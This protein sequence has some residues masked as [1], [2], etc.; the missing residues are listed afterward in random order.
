MVSKSVIRLLV[1]IF[2]INISGS[3]YSI[4]LL[5][6]EAQWAKDKAV[7]LKKENKLNQL[8]R[9]YKNIRELRDKEANGTAT[10]HELNEL[11]R[12]M[13]QI[14]KGAA[15]IGITIAA[16]A[17]LS[18]IGLYKKTTGKIS[19][20][21]MLDAS[22]Y[23]ITAIKKKI[24]DVAHAKGISPLTRFTYPHISLVIY[25]IP[26]TN[27]EEA[28]YLLHENETDAIKGWLWAEKIVP[29]PFNPITLTPKEVTVIGEN[30]RSLVI[31]FN[32]DDNRMTQI[33][34]DLKMHLRKKYSRVIFPHSSVRPHI[35]IGPINDDF[36]KEI[37]KQLIDSINK[38]GEFK[39]LEIKKLV[40]LIMTTPMEIASMGS[41]DQRLHNNNVVLNLSIKL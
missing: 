12:R 28:T 20:A 1:I 17:A 41:F 26:F 14:K 16:I 34:N 32:D 13:K 39:K 7:A 21:I 3:I 36:P 24:Q 15:V 8:I 2:L 40:P 22:H 35:S 9:L 25:Q 27:R 19:V 6:S 30:L 11:Q 5:T 33:F 37:L 10:Q 18:A 4:D 38:S 31:E 29:Y 23:D